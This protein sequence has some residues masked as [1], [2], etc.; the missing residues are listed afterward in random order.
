MCRC[1]ELYVRKAFPQKLGLSLV[2]LGFLASSVAWYYAWVYLTFGILFATALAD[3]LLYALM[4]QALVCY[5]CGAEYRDL[6]SLAPHGPFSLET[7]ERHRQSAARLASARRTSATAP[8][9]Q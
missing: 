4:G 2:V 8:T 3:V 1:P 5:R 9:G 6:P 7:H